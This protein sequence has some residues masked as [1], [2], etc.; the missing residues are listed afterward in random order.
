MTPFPTQEVAERLVAQ[1]WS[2]YNGSSSIE[3]FDEVSAHV[4]TNRVYRLTLSDNS[5]VV[6]KISSYGSYFLF[7][8]DHD[9]LFTSHQML[10]GTRW[11][12]FLAEVLPKGGH[13]YTWY[14][15]QYWVAFYTEVERAQ[16]LPPVLS[17]DQI[18][19]LAR[20]IASFHRECSH[21]STH[22]PPTSNSVKGDAIHLLDQLSAEYA[23]EQFGLS[24]D[25]ICVAYQSTHEF[26]MHLEAVR[27]DEWEKIPVLVDWNLGNFSVHLKNNQY[28]LFSR[29]DYDWFRID[30][31]MLDFYFLSRVS[32]Q[33]GDKTSFTYSPHTLL[34]PRFMHF[35]SE[36]HKV[37]P[38]S[39]QEIDFLP[40][41][42]RFFVLNYV[43]REG[44]KFFRT[45]IAEKFRHDA[46][47]VYLPQLNTIDFSRLHQIGM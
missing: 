27:F 32:S 20:E 30:T 9:R 43:I 24:H 5:N 3:R 7:A 1:A 13:A 17:T 22:L 18:G 46:A 16:Q 11:E 4:S 25:E 10:R 35:L 15:G 31:R 8:E 45:D 34:E 19:T 37:F 36:Y 28:E 12:H 41:A 2:E 21:I 33:T 26:L 23:S 44:S 47:T 42:Y 6:A 38:L 39:P 40:W 14:D 29:W